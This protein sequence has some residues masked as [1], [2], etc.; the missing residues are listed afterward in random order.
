MFTP[1]G[2]FQS[3]AANLLLDDFPNAEAA[4]SVRKLSN[5]YSGDCMQI[6]R[7]SDAA[8]LDVGFDGDGYLD[9]SAILTFIGAG[10]GFVSK[11]YDQSGNSRDI[12]PTSRPGIVNNGAFEYTNGGK[13]AISPVAN[14][15]YDLGFKVR[16]DKTAAG[17]MKNFTIAE[18]NNTNVSPRMF[19]NYAGSGA[20]GT[21]MLMDV[22][23]G[24]SGGLRVFDGNNNTSCKFPGTTIDKG[25][26]ISAMTK[27]SGTISGMCNGDTSSTGTTTG[28]GDSSDTNVYV[29]DDVG[30]SNSRASAG[31]SEL[32]IWSSTGDFE[33]ISANMNDF[34]SIY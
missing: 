5:D 10:D 4:Y 29:F 28:Y 32:V 14:Y 27:D 6:Y 3:A 34:Y 1:I 24:S 18:P 25:S 7:D 8:T 11:W 33:G 26:T 21:Q 2:F 22:F 15:G 17:V 12:T 30:G 20:V 31:V 13:V 23:H 19:G 16:G 9:E